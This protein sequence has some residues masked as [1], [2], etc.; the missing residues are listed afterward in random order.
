MDPVRHCDRL[1]WGRESL[2][3]CFFLGLLRPI[4][5]MMFGQRRMNVDATSWRCIDINATMYR[6]HVPAEVCTGRHGSFIYPLGVTLM[7]RCADVMC[8]LEFVLVVMVRLFVL[9][10]S[11]RCID[12]N[13]TMCRRHVPAGV[14]TGRHGCLFVLLVSWRCIDINATMCRRHVP[15]GVCTGRHGSFICPLGVTGWLL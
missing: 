10:V 5:N 11:W 9:L 4:E 14:C 1:T 7:R 6:R 13:A 3:L 12:I 15:V 2:L 8:P